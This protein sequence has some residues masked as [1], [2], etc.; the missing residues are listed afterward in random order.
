[1]SWYYKYFCGI[2]RKAGAF[3]SKPLHCLVSP[4]L[5][6]LISCHYRKLSPSLKKTDS[7]ISPGDT[8]MFSIACPLNHG[9]NLPTRYHPV[10]YQPHFYA[11]PLPQ[12]PQ[13]RAWGWI[14]LGLWMPCKMFVTPVC[15]CP[16]PLAVTPATWAVISPGQRLCLLLL[17]QHHK[18]GVLI[19]GSRHMWYKIKSNCLKLVSFSHTLICELFTEL[20]SDS[21]PSNVKLLG[22]A[23]VTKLRSEAC[24]CSLNRSCLSW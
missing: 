1:M 9:K 4:W 7:V 16:T 10:F 21:F 2:G 13:R 24:L 22:C 18:A 19:E 23:R 17:G 11:L 14:W 15:P 3:T 12:I 8:F 6:N 5:L 20:A